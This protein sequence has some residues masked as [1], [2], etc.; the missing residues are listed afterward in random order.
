MEIELGCVRETEKGPGQLLDGAFL[1]VDD[2]IDDA[3]SVEEKS[4]KTDEDDA[5]RT[6]AL[7]DKG[8]DTIDDFWDIERRPS[9]VDREGAGVE[10][11]ML[12][13]VMELFSTSLVVTCP[14]LW[15]LVRLGEELSEVGRGKGG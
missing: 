5:T 3:V 6:G 8:N 15:M 11:E 9:C 14:C 4:L 7:V 2:F 12:F 1:V 10:G 13:P